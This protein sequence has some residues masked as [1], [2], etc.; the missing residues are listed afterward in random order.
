MAGEWWS[1]LREAGDWSQYGKVLGEFR[2]RYTYPTLQLRERGD[3]VLDHTPE[4][5]RVLGAAP[6][7]TTFCNHS[8]SNRG[9]APDWRYV[10]LL[11]R[12]A[13]RKHALLT[14]APDQGDALVG[15]WA[16][17]HQRLG[18]STGTFRVTASPDVPQELIEAFGGPAAGTT[19]PR[20]PPTETV[21]G[22]GPVAEPA[23]PRPRPA[24]PPP[25]SPTVAPFLIGSLPTR[26][27]AFQDRTGVRDKV[28]RACEGRATTAMTQVFSGGGGVGKSQLA[29]SYAHQALAAGTEVVVWVDAAESDQIT[30]LYAQAARRLEVAG[31][32]SENAESDARAFMD[33]LSTT[34]RSW[35]VVLDD[36]TDLDAADAW[37]PPPALTGNGRVLATT[38]RREAL[39]S[40]AGRTVIPVDT[41]TPDEAAAYLHER[42]TA[43][44]ITDPPEDHAALATALGHLPLALSH[45]A[46]YMINE[47]VSSSEYLDLFTDSTRRLDDVMPRGADTERYGREVAAALLLSLDAAQKS[48][49][50]GLAT[51]ALRLA[52][53]LDPAGHPRTLWASA[54]LDAHMRAQRGEQADSGPAPTGAARS[55]LRLLH[56]YG[57]LTDDARNGARAVQIH[58]LTARAALEITPPTELP[59]IVDAAANALVEI[60]PEADHTD[61]ELHAV[62]R[63][64]TDVL[65]THAGDLL[66][67]ADRRDV[68]YRTGQNLSNTGLYAAAAIY[69]QR[70]AAE[71]ERLLGSEHPDTVIA[72]A[73]LAASYGRAGRTEEAIGIEER[74]VAVRERLLGSDHLG[75]VRGW[76]NLAVSYG[77]AGRVQEAVGIEERVVAVRER[78]LGSEHP[79]T[80][81]AW[82]NL[83]A[84]YGR[85]GRTE[86]AI[87]IA[88]RVVAVR[89]RLLGSDHLDTVRGWANLAVSYGHAGRVQEAVGIEEQVM[90]DRERLLGP[91]HPDTV[92]ARGNLSVS[93]AEAG[94]VQEAIGIGERVVADR[95]RLLGS[96]HPDTVRARGNLAV[97]YAE[98]GRV[99]EAIGIEGRVVADCERLLGSDHPDTVRARGNLA[100]SYAEAGR[101]QE[102]IGMGEQVVA[103]SERLLGPDHPDTVRAREN[104][105]AMRDE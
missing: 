99:Q 96:D 105:A 38:R 98:A 6:S 37:W 81:I 34:T 32:G 71:S 7:G 16:Q 88:E 72:W 19:P 1:D 83:A 86:E 24:A 68:L 47:G 57:L 56:R 39:L 103:D 69:W 10:E 89:E 41:Y 13:T 64:N 94:R 53:V 75:T 17:Q 15:W 62:L 50:V 22:P 26:A 3:E 28:D 2:V 80:A 63:A 46:A 14:K 60:W 40:G 82:A 59:A 95:E 45:A 21:D 61:R 58:A 27:S 87:G 66:W 35:L 25:P 93:Y 90:A 65:H 4:L 23:V 101:V 51:P 43:E 9:T 52:A 8:S 48:D 100:V 73:N 97:S 85:A 29:A 5:K 55:A 76:A 74:V 54:S 44:G 12:I 18:G 20:T 49:P 42:L 84:S 79:D 31:T 78:L 33:W 11:L 91:D 70:L 36:L 104:L 67:H 30:T 77:H 102:A 92:L